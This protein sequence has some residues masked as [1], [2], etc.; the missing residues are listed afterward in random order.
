MI[1][2][3]C[4]INRGH[5]HRGCIFFT[6]T[7]TSSVNLLAYTRSFVSFSTSTMSVLHRDTT[8]LKY[9]RFCESCRKFDEMWTECAGKESG[10]GCSCKPNWR[11]EFANIT[12]CDNG[13]SNETDPR[14][15]HLNEPALSYYVNKLWDEVNRLQIELSPP[16]PDQFPPILR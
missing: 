6:T 7:T 9:E 1:H 13:Y 15:K 4:S 3:I 10:P 16:K 2:E 12:P 14:T 8:C 11:F 5:F